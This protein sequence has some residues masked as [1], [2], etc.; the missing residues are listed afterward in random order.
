MIG[1]E[2]QEEKQ[3]NLYACTK[4]TII[5]HGKYKMTLYEAD[6]CTVHNDFT[7]WIIKHTGTKYSVQ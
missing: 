5:K 2:P 4:L 6:H 7:N 3:M 1:K